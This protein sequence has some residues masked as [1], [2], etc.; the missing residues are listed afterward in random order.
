M[1]NNS[2]FETVEELVRR[3][4]VTYAE[5]KDALETCD[6]DITEAIILLEKQG[7][8]NSD[9]RN[10]TSGSNSFAGSSSSSSGSG[11]SFDKEKFKKTASDCA[12]GIRETV[13]KGNKTY[14]EIMKDGRVC[15]SIPVTA[16]VIIGIVGFNLVIPFAVI[17]IL[18][19]YSF[20]I[21]KKRQDF[22]SAEYQTY[23][24]WTD[25][26]NGSNSNINL[27]K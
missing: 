21:D 26:N 6:W 4:H 1:N 9:N 8:L 18:L 25:G 16:A 7:K 17:M 24:S 14:F 20:H 11:F 13:D 5:A 10:F 27:E 22:V 2:N 23:Q 3:A 15:V 12:E 19:G